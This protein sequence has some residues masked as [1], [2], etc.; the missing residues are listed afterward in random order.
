MTASR[1]IRNRGV[2]DWPFRKRDNARWGTDGRRHH[3]AGDALMIGPGGARPSASGFRLQAELPD[4]RGAVPAFTRPPGIR[5]WSFGGTKPSP[6]D[7]SQRLELRLNTASSTPYGIGGNRIAC[8]FVRT[9][10]HSRDPTGPAVPS[11][12][13]APGRLPGVGGGILDERF[14]QEQGTPRP[15]GG[16]VRRRHRGVP[17]APVV[18]G[19]GRASALYGHYRAARA[20]RHQRPAD[21]LRRPRRLRGLPRRRRGRSARGAG[22]SGSAARPATGRCSR[23]WRP[24][25]RRSRRAPIPACCARGATR[26]ARGSRRRSRRSWSPSTAPK[27]P[28]TACHKRARAEDLLRAERP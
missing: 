12:I 14:A 5:R 13:R 9:S 11:A 28:C 20:R 21:A 22:T 25:A 15:H 10:L 2:I 23:T 3:T 18:D 1:R 27:G 16:A 17:R 7:P 24:A 26:P 6:C 19:A 4:I 8:K